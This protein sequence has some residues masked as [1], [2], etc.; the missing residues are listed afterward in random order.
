[1]NFVKKTAQLIQN[2]IK[3]KYKT[4][5][6]NNRRPAIYNGQ[7]VGLYK[8]HKNDS[9]GTPKYVV[10]H[11]EATNETPLFCFKVDLPRLLNAFRTHNP[12]TIVNECK[13]M[14]SIDRDKYLNRS[15]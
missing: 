8:I 7:S 14:R 10:K 1:L 2:E 9:V 12:V 3:T 13:K 4:K 11:I 5:Y 15:D 6:I